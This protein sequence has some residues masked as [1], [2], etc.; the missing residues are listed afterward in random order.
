MDVDK[1]IVLHKGKIIERG[2][3]DSLM[4]KDGFYKN[5]Y[6]EQMRNQ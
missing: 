6:D 4:I 2:N 5:M 3:H 1:I